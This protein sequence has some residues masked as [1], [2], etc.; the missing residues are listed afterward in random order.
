MEIYFPTWRNSGCK[1]CGTNWK[2]SPPARE[3]NFVK[4]NVSS[5][6]PGLEK[7]G[8]D[9]GTGEGQRK[10]GVKGVSTRKT[11]KESGKTSTLKC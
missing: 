8:S 5:G 2:T 3:S 6:T 4:T 1:S 9:V 10:T 7:R 11:R